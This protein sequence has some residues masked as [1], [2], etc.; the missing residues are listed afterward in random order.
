MTDDT[1]EETT[2]VVAEVPVEVKE[3]A[4][5]KLPYGGLTEEIQDTLERIAFG[6]DLTQRS[7]LERRREDL[8]SDLED[9]R[10]ERRELDAR[11]ENLEQQVAS[12]DEKLSTITTREDKYEAKIEALEASLRHDGMRCDPGNGAV[13]RAASTGGVE[14]AGVV[15]TLK[16]RNPDVPAYAFEDALHDRETWDGFV[17][18]RASLP[19]DERK[20][21]GE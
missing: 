13:Q 3:A 9:R 4:K 8:Q 17:E 11:I 6:E 7:R 16:E 12:I 10:A 1:P 19:V 21:V 20:E 5:E 15:K 14:P 2:R 18:E